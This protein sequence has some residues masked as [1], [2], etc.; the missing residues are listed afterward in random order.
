MLAAAVTVTGLLVA[1]CAGDP[2]AQSVSAPVDTPARAA[3]RPGSHVAAGTRLPVGGCATFPRDHAF[4]ADVRTLPVAADSG[5]RIAAAGGAGTA[6]RLGFTAGVWEGSR[7]GIPVN[8]VDPATST[9]TDFVV[10]SI[11]AG[12]SR[13]EDVPLPAEPRIEGWPGRA[14]DKH[15][16]LVDPATCTTRELINVQPPGENLIASLTGS[17]YADAVVGID[18][19]TNAPPAAAVTASGLSLLSGLVRHDEVAS[20]DVG[21]ALTVTLPMV[22]NTFVW[23]ALHSDGRSSDPS[24]PPMGS[25]FRLRPDAD[26]SGLGPQALVVARAMQTYGAVLTDTGPG[27]TVAGE[28]DV[29]WDDADLATL[30]SLSMADLQ[31]VDPTPMVVSPDSHRIR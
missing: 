5:T 26:L 28:P 20:G 16:L 15:L 23:P 25:W 22:R 18:L 8:V 29:R 30:T 1:A 13:P 17:W 3:A 6:L 31:V 2:A 4:H 7:G 10:A 19:S 11:Y 24:A 12:I 9:P 27:L 14:W 21:H